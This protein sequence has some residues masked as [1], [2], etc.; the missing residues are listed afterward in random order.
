MD[1]TIGIQ[2]EAKGSQKVIDEFDRIERGA[3]RLSNN[4]RMIATS[5]GEMAGAVRTLSSAVGIFNNRMK[6]MTGF[7]PARGRGRGMTSFSH[8]AWAMAGGRRGKQTMMYA[9]QPVAMAPAPIPGFVMPPF[10][11]PSVGGGGKGR[12]RGTAKGGQERGFLKRFMFG[13]P[14]SMMGAGFFLVRWI[15]YHQIFKG[16]SNLLTEVVL[17]GAREAV[18]TALVELSAIGFDKRQ[19]DMAFR[20]GANFARNFPMFTT[21]GY[22]QAMSQIGSAMGVN[23][24]GF[25]T[26]QRGTELAFMGG[27][28]SK[29]SPEEFGK[30]LATTLEA[31]RRNKEFEG[32][33]SVERMERITAQ[34]IKAIEVSMAWGPDFASAFRHMLPG[35]QMMGWDLSRSLAFV[36]SL[37][38]A[39][40]HPGQV[41]R[42]GRYLASQGIEPM[43]KMYI[44]EAG[45][46]MK[47][48]GTPEQKRYAKS[49]NAA[50]QLA[51]QKIIAENLKE[52]MDKTVIWYSKALKKWRDKGFTYKQL[53][54]AERWGPMMSKI[55]EVYEDVARET[56]H[57][58]K[59][60]NI[61]EVEQ[62]FQ[63]SMEAVGLIKKK[64][65]A[66]MMFFFQSLIDIPRALKVGEFFSATFGDIAD[67]RFM[68]Q[69][70]R[71]GE[72]KGNLAEDIAVGGRVWQE[73]ANR[74]GVDAANLRAEYVRLGMAGEGWKQ[75]FT[76]FKIFI[77]E[78]DNLFGQRGVSKP[79]QEAYQSIVSMNA[80]TI[81]EGAKSI[82]EFIG[83]TKREIDAIN[84]DIAKA[85]QLLKG[86]PPATE[87]YNVPE[88]YEDPITRGIKEL[89]KGIAQRHR[90]SF[91]MPGNDITWGSSADIYG[92]AAP[93]VNVNVWVGNREIKDLVVETIQEMAETT[94]QSASSQF[95]YPV[96]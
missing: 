42:F 70:W 60:A 63:E 38:T 65:M 7:M 40:F 37:K 93:R 35:F 76:T 47:V 51:A 75:T 3:I 54:E 91:L 80:G 14:G 21:E 72:Y 55:G 68:L 78:I 24:V 82:A 73:M 44:R 16:L 85:A 33:G 83:M 88:G 90:E 87:F 86:A 34:L 36:G 92:T 18:D 22:I 27:A 96:Q 50:L 23:E 1:Q 67:L 20:A 31:T 58:L 84:Q 43:A 19:K 10:E 52:N 71:K 9:P 49:Y 13:G 29:M 17:G 2:F 45:V 61:G 28:L 64:I 46:G 77:D 62:R 56:E 26:L 12:G 32:M 95:D 53:G 89:H 79:L 48:Q 39:G 59:I 41:G 8:A 69:T 25:G 66:N 6:S 4:F 57:K 81:G 5:L 74:W 94:G 15:I 30:L 11:Q